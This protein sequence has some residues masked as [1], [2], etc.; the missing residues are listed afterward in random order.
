MCFFSQ[1]TL[2]F[3]A[4]SAAEPHPPWTKHPLSGTGTRL[5]VSRAPLLCPWAALEP[6]A[7]GA[8]EARRAPLLIIFISLTLHHTH[9]F[10]FLPP[11]NMTTCT[12][13]NVPV[14]LREQLYVSAFRDCVF[15]Q[16]REDWHAE[17]TAQV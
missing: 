13:L 15:T 8:S 1:V 4:T 3:T 5:Q 6:S 10:Y 9:C 14:S 16:S 2:P 17:V 7:A 12:P 11:H